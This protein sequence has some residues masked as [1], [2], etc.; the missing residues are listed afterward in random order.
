VVRT[1]GFVIVRGLLKLVGLGPAPDAKDVEIAVLRHQLAVLGRQ[2]N[3]PRHAVADRMRLATLARLL[4]RERWPVFLGTP[5]TLLRWH[6]E[7]VAHRWT[8]PPTGPAR[9]GLSCPVAWADG[10]MCGVNVRRLHGGRVAALIAAAVLMAGGCSGATSASTPSAA[11]PGSLAATSPTGTSET[12]SL[13]PDWDRQGQV[14]IV[15]PG[16]RQ[17]ATTIRLTH[18]TSPSTVGQADLLYRRSPTDGVPELIW[19][20]SSGVV[21][22]EDTT[23]TT[24]SISDCQRAV[25]TAPIK[26]PFRRL[27]LGVVLCIQTQTPPGLAA[28][29]LTQTPDQTG[30]LHGILFY[31]SQIGTL[32]TPAS[33]SP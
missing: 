33:T 8:F 30:T 11:V 25:T 18:G 5:A 1:L 27:R 20:P 12:K 6:R 3:R 14:T 32:A 24:L 9:R 26:P 16:D 31:R 10:L 13:P 19:T 23:T 17:H 7:S 22:S 28:L 21:V 29:G 4:P 15:L 2:V